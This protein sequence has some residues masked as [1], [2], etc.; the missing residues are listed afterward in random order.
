MLIAGVFNGTISAPGKDGWL[1]N[2][3]V[4][5]IEK[6]CLSWSAM[7]G[8]GVI[9]KTFFMAGSV[10]QGHS[11]NEEAGEP[12]LPYPPKPPPVIGPVRVPRDALTPLGTLW[13][14]FSSV[15]TPYPECPSGAHQIVLLSTNP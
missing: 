13:T 12:P 6:A 9:D 5:G 10:D 14:V 1:Y 15:D 7:L 2:Y 8:L 4:H 3:V 11:H